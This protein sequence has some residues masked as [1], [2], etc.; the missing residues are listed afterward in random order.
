MLIIMAT[1]M[2][3][4]NKDN[5][6]IC[7]N[8]KRSESDVSYAD[9]LIAEGFS[10][11]TSY[12]DF[13][14]KEKVFAKSGDFNQKLDNRKTKKETKVDDKI[15]G[16]VVLCELTWGLGYKNQNHTSPLHAMSGIDFVMELRK[17]NCILPIVFVSFLSREQQLALS[18]RN[19]IISTPILG[20]YYLQL[21]S[22]PSQWI[23]TLNFSG[24]GK[25]PEFGFEV[26]K[27]LTGIELED[28]K[29]HF[30]DSE[31][32]LRE[33]NHDLR[34]YLDSTKP[35]AERTQQFEYVFKKI[36]DIIGPH[37]DQVIEKLKVENHI[38]DLDYEEKIKKVSVSI[39]EF[40]KNIK[41]ESQPYCNQTNNYKVIFLDDEMDIDS[42]LKI[43]VQIMDKNGFTV[44]TFTDP[45]K[46]LEEVTADKDNLIDLIISDHRIWNQAMNPKFMDKDQGYT[47]LQKCASLHHTYTYVVFSAL[48]R[49]FLMTQFGLSVKT[50]YKNGV[51]SNESSMINFIYNLREWGDNNKKSI[52]NKFTTHKTFIKCYNWYRDN[53]N[54]S[55][56]DSEIDE[57]SESA[58]SRFKEITL[59]SVLI[60]KSGNTAERIQFPT[61][62]NHNKC[63]SCESCGLY[64]FL[65]PKIKRIDGLPILPVMKSY[66]KNPEKWD[67]KNPI[68]VKNLLTKLAAR[69]LYL[70]YFFMLEKIDCKYREHIVAHLLIEGKFTDKDACTVQSERAFKF[71]PSKDIWMTIK[72]LKWSLQENNFLRLHNLI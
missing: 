52:A 27:E 25:A 32:M 9:Q 68:H 53:N 65:G 64:H 60:H 11:V 56:L 5:V 35:F 15:T 21:P 49:N 46:A 50:L 3:E 57:L 30:C 13:K 72:H 1:T 17:N 14:E 40:I 39:E 34:K 8:G 38:E 47:F 24:N 43:L 19:E 18:S 7:W 22:E 71:D 10:V 37:S 2:N 36:K 67:S 16:L 31:G 55:K 63:N 48:D 29:S 28:V 62:C 23:E 54:K 33:L 58:I 4:L 26:K 59:K 69:R 70:F 6:L 66:Y 44:H 45:D 61:E 51:L 41:S 42:R 20:H 12:S